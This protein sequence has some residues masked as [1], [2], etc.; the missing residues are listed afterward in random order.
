M[1]FMNRDI[2]GLKI[3]SYSIQIIMHVVHIPHSCHVAQTGLSCHGGLGGCTLFMLVLI[4]IF[5]KSVS[6]IIH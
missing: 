2:R 6:V 5:F 4:N 1:Y 3:T